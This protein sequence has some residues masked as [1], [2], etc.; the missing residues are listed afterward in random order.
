MPSA[1]RALRDLWRD[2]VVLAGV[3]ADE[4]VERTRKKRGSSPV[5]AME[6]QYLLVRSRRA[7]A[8]GGSAGVRG[9][10]DACPLS[11]LC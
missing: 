4:E 2:A 3:Q 6:V 11:P 5:C 8:G 7:A 9:T 1:S 10:L